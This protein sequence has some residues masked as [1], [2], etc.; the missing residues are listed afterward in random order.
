[1]IVGHGSAV[2]VLR[3][4]GGVE[5]FIGDL[6]VDAVKH[7]I[8]ADLLEACETHKGNV[9]LIDEEGKLKG[10]GM[11]LTASMLYKYGYTKEGHFLDHI[12]GDVVLVPRRVWEMLNG[13][14]D[15]YD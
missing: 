12:V 5:T 13:E 4:N 2:K 14:D 7:V 1:M 10:K 8:D 3:E 15:E 11:N 6:T 9:M